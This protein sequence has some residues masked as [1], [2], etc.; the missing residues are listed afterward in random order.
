MSPSVNLL[1]VRTNTEM[2]LPVENGTRLV[3]NGDLARG[4]LERT[5]FFDLFPIVGKSIDAIV[6]AAVT[7]DATKSN[8]ASH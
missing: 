2:R 6:I 8:L 5:D 1:A 4:F 3:V 7:M